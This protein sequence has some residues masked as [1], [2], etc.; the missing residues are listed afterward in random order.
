MAQG[1]NKR[2]ARKVKGQRKKVVDPM[3][4]KEIYDVKAPSMFNVRNVC[5]TVVNKT[6]GTKISSE[7]L[8]GRVFEVNLANLVDSED[9]SHRKI[10]LIVEEVQQRN[11][12]TNFH[13][14]DF[15]RDMLFS[16]LR[17]WHSLIEGHIDVESKDG[18]R[19]R[20]F[21]I[22]FTA[23]REKQ[24]KKTSYA[25]A[26]QIKDMRRIMLE[27]ITKEV[28][29]RELKDLVKFLTTESI[30]T[31]IVKACAHIFPLQNVYI[32]K[33]KVVKRP[34]FDI[35]KLLEL[36]N[37]PTLAVRQKDED[38]AAQNTLTAELKP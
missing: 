30:N 15:T 38:E 33:V 8:K 28:Q 27:E 26:S 29:S 16:L 6:T 32:R 36:Y 34:R 11:C 9:M 22:A 10:K 17:K 24:V 20:L 5:K 1:K 18:Y 25:K 14:M 3:T 2:S 23:K 31:Q 7:A 35:T 13:G 21:V 19:L 12:L 37:E 4:K